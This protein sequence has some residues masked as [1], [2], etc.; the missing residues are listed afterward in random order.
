MKVEKVEEEKQ[1][2]IRRRRRR[3]RSRDRKTLKNGVGRVNMKSAYKLKLGQTATNNVSANSST[4]GQQVS[5][6]GKPPSLQCTI[7]T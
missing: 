5:Y 4:T 2:E 7:I 1:K 6:R 3:E